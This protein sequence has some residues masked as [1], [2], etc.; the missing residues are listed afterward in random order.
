MRASQMHTS[1]RLERSRTLT[2]GADCCDF[3]YYW[4]DE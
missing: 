3:T 4:E 1:L 2:E